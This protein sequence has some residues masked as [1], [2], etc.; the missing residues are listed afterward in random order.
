MSGNGHTDP[1]I[2]LK[3]MNLE[4]DLTALEAR[5][6]QCRTETREKLAALAQTIASWAKQMS[7]DIKAVART[8]HGRHK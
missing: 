3:V 4:R 1:R 6:R 7:D 8:I 5:C 2:P